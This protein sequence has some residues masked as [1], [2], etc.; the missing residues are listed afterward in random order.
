MWS[1][2]GMQNSAVSCCIVCVMCVASAMLLGVASFRQREVTLVAVTGV[3]HVLA[4][5]VTS[6]RLDVT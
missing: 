5:N 4:G 6:T 3:L 2:S 1:Y